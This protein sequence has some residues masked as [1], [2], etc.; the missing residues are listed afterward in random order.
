MSNSTAANA[1]SGPEMCQI[2]ESGGQF[3]WTMPQL[4]ALYLCLWPFCVSITAAC[5]TM[6]CVW[7]TRRSLHDLRKAEYAIGY[8]ESRRDERATF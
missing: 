5:C 7:R 8:L 2:W 4:I 1:N 6:R 3:D